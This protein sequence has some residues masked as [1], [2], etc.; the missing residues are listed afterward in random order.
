[1]S[2]RLG[3]LLCWDDPS[4]ADP[5]V[6]RRLPRVDWADG[7]CPAAVAVPLAEGVPPADDPGALFVRGVVSFGLV[8]ALSVSRV[9]VLGL[10][11]VG[12]S[13]VVLGLES[14]L[15]A[16]VLVRTVSRDILS[17]VEVDGPVEGPS[18]TVAAES[19]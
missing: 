6:S 9:L 8:V 3:L 12:E 2:D 17:V 7:P 14:V 5:V 4:C 15:A 1:M 11:L 19:F 18:A 13:A 16:D 10:V